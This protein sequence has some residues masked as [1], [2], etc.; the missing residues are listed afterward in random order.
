M[1]HSSQAGNAVEVSQHRHLARPAD[2]ARYFSIGRTTLYEW[3]RR[4]G[5]PKPLKPSPRVTLL[6]VNEIEAFLASGG[7]A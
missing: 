1:N 7:A 6:C 3:M 2:V 4:P 5:F